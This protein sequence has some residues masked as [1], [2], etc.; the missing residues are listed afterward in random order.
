LFTTLRLLRAVAHAA[1][2]LAATL[3]V[4]L[5]GSAATAQETRYFGIWGYLENTPDEEIA[6]ESL[7]DRQLGYWEVEFDAGGDTVSAVYRGVGGVRWLGFVYAEEDGRVYADLFGAD[8][9]YLRRKS[10]PLVNRTPTW[11]EAD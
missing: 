9:A 4:A 2:P 5:H 8:G 7:A 1:L 10:T 11:P 6:A 3:A